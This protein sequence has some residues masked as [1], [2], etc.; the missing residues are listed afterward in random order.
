MS[1]SK[2]PGTHRALVMQSLKRNFIGSLGLQP[3]EVDTVQK[4][5]APEGAT[6]AGNLP[7]DT[8]FWALLRQFE[9][10]PL[11]SQIPSPQAFVDVAPSDLTTFGKTLVTVR[12]QAAQRLQQA[13]PGVADTPVLGAA[14]DLLN[15]AVVQ[16]NTFTGNMAT[17]QVG[18]L[19]LE[20]L[21]MTPVGIERGGLI[22]TIPLAPKEHTW[23]TRKTGTPVQTGRPAEILLEP[24]RPRVLERR[25]GEGRKYYGV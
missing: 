4:A 7:A 19:N 12:Q 20:R 8:S 17:S 25:S 3:G 14:I 10:T 22:A 21:E 15:R 18:M 6:A 16:S 2:T 9:G 24:V 5:L 1:R 13:S 11:A 23:S